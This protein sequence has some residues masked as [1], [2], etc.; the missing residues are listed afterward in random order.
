MI[1]GTEAERPRTE[2]AGK[3]PFWRQLV[4]FSMVT[5]LWGMG[6][7]DV[8]GGFEEPGAFGGWALLPAAIGLVSIG[9]FGYKHR[10]EQLNGRDA[11]IAV[12]A[13]AMFI[14]GW[15]AR[16]RAA[17]EIWDLQCARRI[18]P[19]YCYHAARTLEFFEVGGKDLLGRGCMGS[20]PPLLCY[21]APPDDP[22]SCDQMARVCASAR[23]ARSRQHAFVDP[24]CSVF[25]AGCARAA[26]G[27][28]SR[29]GRPKGPYP[30]PP[31]WP[32]PWSKV[33]DATLPAWLRDGSGPSRFRKDAG[34]LDRPA[35]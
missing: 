2:A 11:L 27:G 23:D 15:K 30:W 17:A 8:L 28:P 7:S 16:D 26:A 21:Y 19:I 5:T 1:T 6:C 4:V 9:L 10:K 13:M 35:R 29:T 34:A 22:R 32:A 18:S 14:V 31:G 24:I 3:R 25:T 33:D 12:G 20:E